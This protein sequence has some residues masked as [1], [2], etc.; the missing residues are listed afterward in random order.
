RTGCGR[1]PPLSSWGPRRPYV[2]AVDGQRAQ[3]PVPYFA[4]VECP[5]PCHSP[6]LCSNR[7]L[8][9][10]KYLARGERTKECLMPL[11]AAEPFV[12]PQHL[13]EQPVSDAVP[14]SQWW[15]LHTRARA[16]KSVARIAHRKEVPFFLPQYTRRWRNQGRLF[17]A[18]LPLFPG[19]VFLYADDEGRG[20]A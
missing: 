3:H 19:Y 2:Q 6:T 12:Y 11:L 4:H 7:V 1:P 18:Q 10:G 17:T 9:L 14:S 8:Q 13:F 16:E 15:V 5:K 20:V